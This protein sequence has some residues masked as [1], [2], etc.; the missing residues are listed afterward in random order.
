MEE[1]KH[2]ILSIGDPSFVFTIHQP[3]EFALAVGQRLHHGS[4]GTIPSA[5]NLGILWSV[6]IV[7]GTT[8]LNENVILKAKFKDEDEVAGRDNVTGAAC[9]S[10]L[11][12][13]GHFVC[14]ILE[15]INQSEKRV[16]LVQ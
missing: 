9:S 7:D 6:G 11:V 4:G 16:Q 15:A 3:S 14:H 1:N 5:D 12:G 8:G 13:N 2:Y 10:D